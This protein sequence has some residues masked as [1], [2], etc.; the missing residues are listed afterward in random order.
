MRQLGANSNLVHKV[1]AQFL[2]GAGPEANAKFDELLNGFLNG[3]LTVNDIRAQAQSAANQL[4]AAKKELGDDA[5]WA[6]EG[7]L[8]ILDHFLKETGGVANT[9]TSTTTPK[10]VPLS[11]EEE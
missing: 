11:A 2:S 5:G 7:Y 8:A 3:K 4:R 10:A 6:I 1:Q 9:P